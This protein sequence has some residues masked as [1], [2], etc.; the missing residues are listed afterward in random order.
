MFTPTTIRVLVEVG[1]RL[2]IKA[3][4]AAALVVAMGVGAAVYK[5]ADTLSGQ[6]QQALQWA[7][8]QIPRE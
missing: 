7:R 1:Q 8:R 4:G 2:I 6:T 5:A 3:K